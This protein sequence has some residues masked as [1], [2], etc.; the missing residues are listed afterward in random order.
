VASAP[1]EDEEGD[2]TSTTAKK[3]AAGKGRPRKPTTK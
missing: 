3:P 1:A 2:S